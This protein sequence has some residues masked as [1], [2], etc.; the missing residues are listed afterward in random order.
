M[1]NLFYCNFD[2][3]WYNNCNKYFDIKNNVIIIDTKILQCSNKIII[4]F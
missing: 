2:V 4:F 3:F 1:I